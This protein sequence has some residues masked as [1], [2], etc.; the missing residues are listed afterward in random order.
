MI[1][2]VLGSKL[3]PFG[4]V[5]N[6]RDHVYGVVPPWAARV[7]SYELPTVPSGTV[8]VVI[9]KSGTTVRPVDPVTPPNLAPI[10]VVPAPTACTLDWKP[11]PATVATPLAELD[12]VA[13]ALTFT[14]APPANVPTALSE[15]VAPAA[16]RS[17]PGVTAIELRRCTE[18]HV[19][20]CQRQALQAA[21]RYATFAELLGRVRADQ[22]EDAVDPE[23][24]SCEGPGHRRGNLPRDCVGRV[25][26]DR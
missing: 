7:W 15:S 16:R 24:S 19:A 18:V 6:A 10:V 13:A 17:L 5:P 23:I 12:Q 1:S 3:S 4:S 25:T 8:I 9:T 14:C 22:L 21:A 2:P 20:T 26:R 11:P